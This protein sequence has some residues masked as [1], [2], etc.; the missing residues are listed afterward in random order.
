MTAFLPMLCT[1]LAL[2]FVNGSTAS[3]TAMYV[4]ESLLA[5]GAAYF[6]STCGRCAWFPAA[7]PD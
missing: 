1:G 6:F 4:A 7:F 5:G 3:G 2:A